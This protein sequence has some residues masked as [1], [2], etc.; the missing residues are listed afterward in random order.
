MIVAREPFSS[1]SS[2]V[3]RLSSIERNQPDAKI[4][5]LGRNQFLIPGLVDLHTHAPQFRNRALGSRYELLGW[6]ENVT[7]PEEKRFNCV[8]NTDSNQ[9]VSLLSFSHSPH[10]SSPKRPSKFL[11]HPTVDILRKWWH[12][13]TVKWLKSTSKMGPPRA[14]TLEAFIPDRMRSWLPVSSK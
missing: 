4:V 10:I 2:L 1:Y 3:T 5:R 6:L 8:V 13:F 12:K 7:F 9:V 14:S 11:V